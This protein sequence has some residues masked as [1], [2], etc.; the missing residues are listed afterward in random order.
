MSRCVCESTSANCAGSVIDDSLTLEEPEVEEVL[1]PSGGALVPDQ[2]NSPD[3]GHCLTAVRRFCTAEPCLGKAHSIDGR[4]DIDAVGRH[5][6]LEN[7]PGALEVGDGQLMQ[8]GSEPAQ[9]LIDPSSVVG[10]SSVQM[11]RSD[12]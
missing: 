11:S 7:R 3:H 6:N 12:L 10:V 5:A 4:D 9:S 2:M 1:G 8:R